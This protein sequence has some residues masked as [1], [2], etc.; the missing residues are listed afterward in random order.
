M[1]REFPCCLHAIELLWICCQIV[2]QIYQHRDFP[3]R[4]CEALF[5]VFVKIRL[6][7]VSEAATI[8]LIFVS[9]IK[10]LTVVLLTIEMS[11]TL[12]EIRRV[13]KQRTYS[14]WRQERLTRSERI[15]IAERFLPNAYIRK[16]WVLAGISPLAFRHSLFAKWLNVKH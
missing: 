14:T 11:K 13:F 16:S 1:E 7:F 3:N 15:L 10:I 4:S 2:M 5:P 8:E 12:L 9:W 6:S